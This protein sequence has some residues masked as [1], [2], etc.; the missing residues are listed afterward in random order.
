MIYERIKYPDGTI[1]A[2]IN[3]FENPIII[4]KINTYEDLFFIKSLK[5]VCDYNNIKNVILKIPCMFH[6]QHDRR[7]NTNE[8]FDLKLI[9]EFI[10]SCNFNEV[11]V[12]HPHSDVT[13]MGL[14]NCH[15]IDNTEFIKNVLKDIKTTPILFSTDAGSFKWINKLA[16]NLKYEG[17]IYA[18]SKSRNILDKS[19]VQS[20][21]KM[22]F[23]K[24]DILILDDLCV[25]GG[26]FMGLAKIL[27]K[28][29]IGNLY[30]AVSHITVSNP[31][32]ELE[33]LYD[34][35]YCTNSKYNNYNLSNLVIINQ[36]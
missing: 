9:C 31:N 20:I 14:N 18:A 23:E 26:T 8:S 19:I 6:Q 21:D 30:L 3:N 11:H 22:D 5:D 7:F 34:K 17:E 36:F 1:Y 24:K 2:K 29:N 25:Y 28:R 27:K 4:E 16:N 33:S 15:I 35:I 13:Q 12:Y 32:L 10:N